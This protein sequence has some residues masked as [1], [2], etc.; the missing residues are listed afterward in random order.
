MTGPASRQAVSGVHGQSAVH[1]LSGERRKPEKSITEYLAEHPNGNRC[2]RCGDVVTVGPET[3]ACMCG[4]CMRFLTALANGGY[5]QPPTTPE[6]V[7]PDCG[8]PI[9]PRKQRCGPCRKKRRRESNRRAQR[10]RRE[11]DK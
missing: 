6:R 2:S 11:K 10:T 7:C 9:E 8:G 4:A 5:F 1:D 3:E